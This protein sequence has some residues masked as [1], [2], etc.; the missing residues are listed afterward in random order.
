MMLSSHLPFTATAPRGY[1]I[2]GAYPVH[3]VYN[4][5]LQTNSITTMDNITAIVDQAAASAD[6]R[7]KRKAD[8]ISQCGTELARLEEEIRGVRDRQRRLME[9]NRQYDLVASLK[10]DGAKAWKGLTE[11]NK[12]KKAN[13]LAVLVC[14]DSKKEGLPRELNEYSW[15]NGDTVPAAL[16]EDRDILLAR[17]ANKEF[18]SNYDSTM[19]YPRHATPI[20]RLPRQFHGDKEVAIATVKKYPEILKQDVLSGELLD[21]EELFFAYLHSDRLKFPTR[22]GAGCDGDIFGTLLSKFSDGIRGNAALMLEAAKHIKKNAILDHF[23]ERLAGDCIFAKELVALLDGTPKDDALTRFADPVRA[24]REIVLALVQKNGRCLQDASQELK[25]DDEILRAACKDNASALLFA[26]PDSRAW[27]Q[28]G[29]D[30]EFLMD[31]FSRWPCKLP[32]EPQLYRMV[33]APLKLDQDIVVAAHKKGNLSFADLPEE[34]TG[35]RGFWTDVIKRDSSIWRELPDGFEGDPAFARVINR[36]C[37]TALVEDVFTRFPFLL[38]DRSLWFV[39][40]AS[41]EDEKL[42][43]AIEAHAPEQIRSDKASTIGIVEGVHCCM[44]VTSCMIVTNFV[45]VLAG[46]DDPR[47]WK[48]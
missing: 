40:I 16:H 12:W 48:G 5:Q 13:V 45:Y 10:Q 41:F 9:Q 44:T 30:K 21:D 15:R 38:N 24:N 25:C 34:L 19:Y 37:D 46:V 14:S 42:S 32:G 28:L 20:F 22:V 39:V 36:F 2:D 35:D 6:R 7:R 31:V 26:D 8:E 4:Y 33:S 1:L 18:Q 11:E 27:C 3:S 29:K 17:L 43:S 23:S 47:L